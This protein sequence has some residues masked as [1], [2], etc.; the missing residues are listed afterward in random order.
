MLNYDFIY[1]DILV[2]YIEIA[3]IKLDLLSILSH[4]YLF[5]ANIK[6]KCWVINV[7]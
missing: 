3:I 6:Y 4:Q 5:L 1:E 7:Y 2:S